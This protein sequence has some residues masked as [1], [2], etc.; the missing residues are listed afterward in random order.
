M[1]A[2]WSE[3]DYL[4]LMHPQEGV[5]VLLTEER[6][7]G[8][9]AARAIPHEHVSGPQRRMHRGDTRHVVCVPGIRD[10]F[11][12]QPGSHMTQGEEVGDW[13]APARAL[14]SWLAKVLLEFQGIGHRETRSLPRKVRCPCHR[15]SSWGVCSKAADVRRTNCGQTPR[16][17]RVRT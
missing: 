4:L 8:T 3:I 14:P 7:R 6:Q 2:L 5:E 15:P 16:G 13:E 1:G 9:G 17:N 12:E 11:H 10:D